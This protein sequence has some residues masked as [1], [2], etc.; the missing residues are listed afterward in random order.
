MG[1]V[2]DWACCVTNAFKKRFSDDIARWLV[3]VVG[4]RAVPCEFHEIC[5][6]VLY[7]TRSSPLAE[8]KD[9]LPQKAKEG[10]FDIST[11]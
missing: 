5:V 7:E 8:R 1:D 11:A 9:I 4:Q 6:D 2:V 10:M 3:G